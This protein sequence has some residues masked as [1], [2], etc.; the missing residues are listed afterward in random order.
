MHRY[1]VLRKESEELESV[2]VLFI[3]DDEER[4]IYKKDLKHKIL[5]KILQEDVTGGINSLEETLG[6]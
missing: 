5:R 4:R 6:D 1:Y 3:D 2:K